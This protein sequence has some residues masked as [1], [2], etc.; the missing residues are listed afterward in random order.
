LLIIVDLW[1]INLFCFVFL[2]HSTL[3]QDFNN[4]AKPSM[5]L[6]NFDCHFRF[7]LMHDWF[8][9]ISMSVLRKLGV[10]VLVFW[11]GKPE[12]S[13]VVMT[14]FGSGFTLLVTLII[15]WIYLDFLLLVFFLIFSLCCWVIYV[16]IIIF[17]WN[18][19]VLC[20]LGIIFYLW[21]E[22]KVFWYRNC[23]MGMITEIHF[24]KGP[25]DIIKSI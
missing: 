16:S 23:F 4:T 19:E 15:A 18:D 7:K 2:G 9:C 13:F 1:L 8:V 10:S 17:V 25:V 12:E 14:C 11:S 22:F 3:K 5:V 20:P 6:S 21:A 24:A